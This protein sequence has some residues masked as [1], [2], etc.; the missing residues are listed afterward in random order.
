MEVLAYDVV[1]DEKAADRL[2]FRYA[3][4]DEL[5]SNS[6]VIT[7]HV[8]A[9][10]KTHHLLSVEEFGKMKDGVVLINTARGSVV[11][12]Q[13]L[14]RAFSEGKVAAAGLDVLPDEPVIREEAELLRSVYR[15]KYDLET[16]LS[17]HILLRLRDVIIT[18]HSAFNTREAVERILNTTVENIAAYARGEPQNVV[19]E[20]D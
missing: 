1:Q 11:D 15:K 5:L 16:L 14:V 3:E 7:L 6:D 9:N 2:G 18:P 12:I 13:A 19:V 10:E 4:M 20:G 17:N 8:P